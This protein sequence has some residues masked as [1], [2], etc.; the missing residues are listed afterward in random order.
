MT[1]PKTRVLI[2]I[3]AYNCE[4]QISRVFEKIQDPARQYIDEIVVI[5]NGSSDGTVNAAIDAAREFPVRTTVVSN[6]SN[7]SLG[8]SI[9]VGFIKAKSEGFS[10][11]FVLH[12]DDQA[13]FRDALGPLEQI[14][15]SNSESTPDAFIGARFHPM[16]HLIGYSRFRK[17]GN[18]CLNIVFGIVTR[19]RIMDLIAGI[20][21]FRVGFYDQNIILR[22]PNSLTFDAH[23][24][25]LT[26]SQKGKLEYFPITWREEDQVSNA[27]TIRQ[28]FVILRLLLT[29]LLQGSRVLA[30]DKSGKTNSGDY[31]G[32]VQFDN[33]FGV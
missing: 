1:I 9:K 31:A 4:R 6:N 10:H 24:L 21:I 27:K 11:V 18:K 8:G 17:F 15:N 19:R 13:D 5:D 22:F 23:M 26:T 20:N 3:P 12:G 32:T 14:H 7:Y 25:L 33:S 28:G 29:Y 2:C 30:K 16:S